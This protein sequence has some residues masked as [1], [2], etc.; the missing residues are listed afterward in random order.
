MSARAAVAARNA[1]WARDLVQLGK[2][3]ITAMVSATGVMGALA[4][5][6]PVE[7]PRFAAFVAGTV[8]VVAGANALNMWLERDTDALMDR[9]RDR[10]LAAGRLAPPLG[11]AFGLALSALSIP[12]LAL[13]G[14]S[15][16]ALGLLALVTYV[17]VYTPLKRRSRWSLPA[18]AVAGA[19]PPAMGW[20]TT[21][22]SLA[23]AA[24][25]FALLFVWQMPH[26]I[27]IAV[28]RGGDYARAGLAVGAATP[29]AIRRAT[30]EVAVLSV[31]FVGVTLASPLV[32]LG[33]A[34]AFAI[35][36]VSGVGL[37]ALA[38]RAARPGAP[39]TTSRDVFAYTMGHLAI[40]LAAIVLD[41]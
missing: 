6:G 7:W 32:G 15:V 30:R 41:R 31:A 10:P 22:S 16:A 36:A 21:S 11:L 5:R 1:S 14:P 19:V 25:L 33:G 39:K 38:L 37:V 8:L 24:Y 29:A 40:A 9:T 34:P 35:C 26:F 28:F 27:A 12:V 4:S 13:A 2:P 18:G 23:G 3:R 20:L 17:A